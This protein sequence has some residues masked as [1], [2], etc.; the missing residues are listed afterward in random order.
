[1]VS[2]GQAG[3]TGL[4]TKLI[5]VSTLL[6]LVA[7]SASFVALGLEIRNQTKR[8]LARV[9]ARQQSMIGQVQQRRLEQLLRTST[10]LTDSPTLRAALETYRAETLSGSE[11]RSD[12]LATIESEARKVAGIVGGDLLVITDD[13][14]RVLASTSRDGVGPHPGEDLSD[15]GAVRRALA[16]DSGLDEHNLAVLD[17]DGRHFQVGAVPVTLQGYI[18]GALALGDRL[19]Q[20]W[21]D[22]LRHSFDCDIVVGSSERILAST[23]SGLPAGSTALAALGVAPGDD[24][25][26]TVLRVDDREYMAAPILLGGDMGERP[27]RLFL[28]HSLSDALAD[29]S[30]TLL[31]SAVVIGLTAVTLACL[32]SGLVARSVL[33]PLGRFVEFVRAVAASGDHSRRFASDGASYEIRTLIEAFGQLGDS[34]QEHQ[35]KL[36]R[37]AQQELE[38]LERLKESEKLAALGRL[39]SGAAHEINNP[40][41]GVVGNIEML[42][43]DETIEGETRRRLETIRAE[44]Q[45]IV[46]LVRNQLRVAYRDVGDCVDVDLNDLLRDTARL[47]QHDFKTAGMELRLELDERP[48]KVLA[49][50]LELQQVFLNVINNAFDALEGATAHPRLTVASRLE[51]G[52]VVVSLIDNGPG[53][54]DAQQVFEHFY[55]TKP[56]GKGTGLGL[57]IS[58][59]IIERHRGEIAA[60]NL[61]GGGARFTVELPASESPAHP[62]KSA[63]APAEPGDDPRG[64]RLP[65]ASVLVVDDE[66][67]VLDLQMAILDSVGATAVGVGSGAE[68][69]ELLE[70][71][72]FDL[73]VSDLRMPGRISGKELF[74]WVET[75]RPAAVRGFVFV[76]GDTIGE[77]EFLESTKAPCILKPFTMEEYLSSLR[78]TLHAQK[79]A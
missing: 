69:I 20:A 36:L 78:E 33:R 11:P 70:Q 77:A 49:N 64:D 7:V 42:L 71:R 75:E 18:I 67:S 21:V 32:V 57:S 15:R 10:L 62:A 28:L 6:T 58:R 31:T 66:P 59:A 51:G 27:V 29:S 12:L 9:V 55:T 17:F 43:A 52:R 39:L 65:R 26:S 30:R 60:E 35:R 24:T 79:A 19:D 38:Q 74:R 61:P 50:S 2:R 25:G 54:K 34:L 46:A 23:L 1:M 5:L 73:I 4:G 76:T 37:K 41:T 13:R 45:R 47:R 72:E 14:G 40:L 56:V 68:A 48:L 63:Q 8:L 16:P 44:G 22:D 3:G 53:L